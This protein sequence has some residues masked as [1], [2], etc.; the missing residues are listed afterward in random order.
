MPNFCPRCNVATDP[1]AAFC[2]ACGNRLNGGSAK[3]RVA[4]ALDVSELTRYL[5]PTVGPSFAGAV[6]YCLKIIAFFAVERREPSLGAG[7]F[8]GRRSF[9]SRR[10]RSRAF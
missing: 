4:D 1:D 5:R 7:S 9:L 8:L 6:L 10:R 2:A 3:R